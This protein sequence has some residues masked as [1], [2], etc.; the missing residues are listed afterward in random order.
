MTDRKPLTKTRLIGFAAMAVCAIGY[1]G[2]GLALLAGK[3]DQI[4]MTYAALAA[5]ILA[6]IGECGLW[7]GAACLGLTLFKKRKA[8][9]DRILRRRTP[10]EV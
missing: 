1:A 10:A 6:V 9:L 7:V 4:S 3:T 5:A 2:A 8:M